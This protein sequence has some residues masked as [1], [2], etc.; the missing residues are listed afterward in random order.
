M[1]KIQAL[2]RGYLSRNIHVQRRFQAAIGK[3]LKAILLI[4]SIGRRYNSRKVVQARRILFHASATRIQKVYRGY[5]CRYFIRCTKAAKRIQRLCRRFRIWKF[6]DAVIMVMQI[7]IGFRRR[8]AKVTFIQRVIRGF[9][10]RNYVFKRRLRNFMTK[11]A[12]KCIMRHYRAYVKRKNYV[13]FICVR[14]LYVR[15]ITMTLL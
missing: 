7:K 10:A 4:Q 14:E 15:T 13:P 12:S 2:W 11:R 3:R 6:Q 8:L 1:V 5:I 9:L